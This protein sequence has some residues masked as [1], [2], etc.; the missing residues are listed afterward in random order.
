MSRLTAL[1]FAYPNTPHPR[2]HGPQGYL[3]HKHYKPWLRDEFSFRCIYCLSR[4]RW[5]PDGDAHFGVDHGRPRSRSAA[6][7]YDDLVY[8]CGVCNA[9]K[10]DYPEPLDVTASGTHLEVQDD[11]TIRALTVAGQTLIDICA[12]DR[13]EL[14]SFRRNL[15]E[16]LALLEQHP[17]V[18]ADRIRQRYLGFPDALPDLASLRPP[19]GNTR[20]DGVAQSSFELRRRGTLP[21]T[22]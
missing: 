22:Y 7:G 2:R 18:N 13:P 21:G 17:G 9:W 6:N 10:S 8:A 12:L 15:I 11:G 19:G 5:L 20:P 4:E 16:L 3:D 14:V 1:A